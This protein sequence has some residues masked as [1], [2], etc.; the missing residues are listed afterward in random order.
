MRKKEE[1]LRAGG[2]GWPVFVQASNKLGR[3]K[4]RRTVRV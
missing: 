4:V 2:P 3:E 1:K